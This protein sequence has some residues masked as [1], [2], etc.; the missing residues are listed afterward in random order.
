MRK[1][2]VVTRSSFALGTVV[3]PVDLGGT[4]TAGLAEV[5]VHHP[6]L[7]PEQVPLACTRGPPEEPSR[8]ERQMNMLRGKFCGSSGDSGE[9]QAA[10]LQRSAH[11]I[12]GDRQAGGSGPRRRCARV[13]VQLGADGSQPRRSA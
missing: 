4:R 2:R 7:R 9:A 10:A 8:L 11:H 6:V 12:V 3:D 1:S 5:I 13:V